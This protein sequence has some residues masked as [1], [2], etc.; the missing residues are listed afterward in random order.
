MSRLAGPDP[1]AVATVPE[2]QAL[3]GLRPAIGDGEEEFSG[4]ADLVRVRDIDLD[5]MRA[6]AGLAAEQRFDAFEAAT[7]GL[8]PGPR[9]AEVRSRYPEDRID[10]ARREYHADPWITAARAGA[11]LDDPH[12]VWCVGH[13]RPRERF[14]A[15]AVAGIGVPYAWLQD[16]QWEQQGYIGMFM[17][18]AADEPDQVAAWSAHIAAR[19]AAL[20]GDLWVANV[21]CHT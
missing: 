1:A 12:E 18:A 5:A 14:V 6:L 21:D 20:D 10:E 4:R 7:A 16:G 9:W 19:W 2:P 13:E 17:A 11:W 8:E 3:L 15:R